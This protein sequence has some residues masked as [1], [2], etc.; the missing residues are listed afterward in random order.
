MYEDFLAD[1][2]ER[3]KSD[4]IQDGQAS[5]PLSP[6]AL[7][8]LVSNHASLRLPATDVLQFGAMMDVQLVNDVS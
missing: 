1:L 7:A 2:R 6:L 8:R 4:R 3:Y 5:P